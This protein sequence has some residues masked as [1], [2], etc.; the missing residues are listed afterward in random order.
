MTVI[1]PLLLLS[2]MLSRTIPSMMHIC[3]CTCAGRINVNSLCVQCNKY[4]YIPIAFGLYSIF[5]EQLT[6]KMLHAKVLPL[7]VRKTYQENNRKKRVVGD[8]DVALAA[9][10]QFAFGCEFDQVHHVIWTQATHCGYLGTISKS[11]PSVR[12]FNIIRVNI[13]TSMRNRLIMGSKS[14]ANSSII[15]E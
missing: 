7:A 1:T 11:K 6:R 15:S 8:K 2:E 4:I 10:G 3:V 5:Y 12:N 9:K 14:T 13:I